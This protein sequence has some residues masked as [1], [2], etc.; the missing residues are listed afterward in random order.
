MTTTQEK[1][2]AWV[3]SVKN[4]DQSRRAVQAMKAGT[5]LVLN[6]LKQNFGT[7]VNDACNGEVNHFKETVSNQIQSF[8]NAWIENQS[9]QLVV[10]PEGTRFVNREGSLLNVV[11]EQ[12]PSVRVINYLENSYSLS[13]P[14]VQFYITFAVENRESLRISQIKISCSK[15]P[16]TSLNDRVY[17]LPLPN[18]GNTLC[19][20]DIQSHAS[21]SFRNTSNVTDKCNETINL[22]W[23][24]QFNNDLND[25]FKLWLQRNFNDEFSRNGE[26]GS[27]NN[28]RLCL[29]SWQEKSK[30]YPMFVLG[31]GC[32]FD[33]FS[34]VS[35]FIS[36]D[37]S[38]RNT[39]TALLNNIAAVVNSETDRYI[40]KVLGSLNS[41]DLEEENRNS[42]HQSVLNE[43]ITVMV[44]STY[45]E[46]WR[47]VHRDHEEKVNEDH[48]ILQNKQNELQNRERQCERLSSHLQAEKD[49]F[50]SQKIGVQLE[51]Y[52]IYN[53]LQEQLAEVEKLKA[54]LQQHF[55]EQG[56]VLPK[57]RRGR[58][59]K[60]SLPARVEQSMDIISESSIPVGPNGET[61]KRRRGRPR[62]DSAA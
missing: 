34:N 18:L 9:N 17:R 58:P 10:F 57:A 7:T 22:F 11:I 27:S 20:G 42:A 6:R 25:F 19:L 33:I 8:C 50:Q 48:R 53:H 23:Q 51:M 46:L 30:T 49:T 13:M 43:Q 62:K 4:N 15:K 54:K 61:L 59:R 39:R 60:E 1:L 24:S 55:D 3:E 28:I 56:N 29:R 2:I 44:N 5:G 21:A 41:V 31:A 38:S 32:E 36:S 47:L 14:Y 40:G 35:S 45:A 37:F 12:K 52:Y 16:I 26:I